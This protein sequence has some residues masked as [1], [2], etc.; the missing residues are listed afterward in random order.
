MNQTEIGKFIAKCRKEKELTQAQLAEK[1]ADGKHS[2]SFTLQQEVAEIVL[3]EGLAGH[4]SLQRE[5]LHV[6]IQHD[7]RVSSSDL[8]V[9][10][11]PIA[12]MPG[13]MQGRLLFPAII[14]PDSCWAWK[15]G[16]S[17]GLGLWW[18]RLWR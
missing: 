17:T 15:T 18:P 5:G 12:M 1:Y 13:W 9:E 16:P 11:V 10:L 8:I 4:C 3:P 14:R 2:V 7:S 6:R